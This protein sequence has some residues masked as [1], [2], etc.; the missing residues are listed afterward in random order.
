MSK[1]KSPAWVKRAKFDRMER[2]LAIA[3][4]LGVTRRIRTRSARYAAALAE[5]LG[6]LERPR[7]CRWCGHHRRLFRHHDDHWLPLAV[8][9][10]CRPCHL[11]ADTIKL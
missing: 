1:R 5:Q 2:H 4:D 7:S 3:N 9:Y 11:I 10:L 6:I 8:L